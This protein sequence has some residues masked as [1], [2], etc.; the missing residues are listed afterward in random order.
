MLLV[1]PDGHLLK[2][3]GIK[4]AKNLWESHQGRFGMATKESKK[5]QHEEGITNFAL[6]AL[7]P[8][9]G[10]SSSSSS[11]S[12]KSLNVRPSAPIIE[13]WDT[14]S[15]NDTVATKLGHVPVNAAKQNSP[16]SQR[17]ISTAM[18][19]NTAAP[20]SKVNDALPKT[21][22]YFKAHSPVRR[23][24]NQ[25]LAA[26]TYNLNEKVKTVRVNNVTTARPKAVV[27]VAVR[28]GE[29]A[30]KSSAWSGPD[31]L[32]NIDL[33]TKSMNYEPVTAG[34]QTNKNACIKDNTQQYILLP[35]LYDSPK[36]SEDVVADDA[37]KKINKEPANEGYAN[38]TN[39]D[40]TVSPPV[41]AA[42]QSFTNADNLPTDPL[43]LDL[44]DTANLLNNSIF[45]GA[46]DDEDVGAKADLNNLE[47]TMNAGYKRDNAVWITTAE[48]K[49]PTRQKIKTKFHHRLPNIPVPDKP[50]SPPPPLDFVQADYPNSLNPADSL[51]IFPE[52]DP[53]WTEYGPEDPDRIQLITLL[54]RADEMMM[55]RQ[56]RGMRR[57]MRK[58]LAFVDSV[59]TVHVWTS[60]YL[61]GMS[62]PYHFLL[63]K[64][65]TCYS[66][67]ANFGTNVSNDPAESRDNY[68][69]SSFITTTDFNTT[70]AI[71][72]VSACM[73]PLDSIRGRVHTMFVDT[74]DT[75]IRR[76]R[77][78]EV[79]YG[80]RDVWID[81]REAVEEDRQTQIYQ[82]VE[83]LVDDSQ[84]HYET[85][86]LLDS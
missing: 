82:S 28:Y 35:L 3:H 50:Q 80:I 45:S 85:A 58:H 75:E 26:K 18:P 16:K 40:S 17:A 24:F 69:T 33:L 65:T 22:S 63:G 73:L 14:D 70:F 32:F 49:V 23:A 55:M 39:R 2:F 76:Q 84:Y 71:E 77:A 78:E 56:G 13:D 48:K 4:D 68:P 54:I 52:S 12:K 31:W 7:I 19:I 72:I 36:S 5:M 10:S 41:S 30:V 79:G 57:R 34:N 53:M 9:Q 86:R 37:G 64:S 81:P 6:L 62:H 21:Y 42:R 83:T 15:D 46:Y 74:M 67:F 29:N 25:K 11:D 43:M 20:K 60:R 38:S 66:L 44:E 61:S 59:P 47:T 51:D 27:S 8:S 1:I